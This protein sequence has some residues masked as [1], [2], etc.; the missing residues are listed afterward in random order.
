MGC[1]EFMDGILFSQHARTFGASLHER[2]NDITYLFFLI[3]NFFSFCK[4]RGRIHSK[5]IVAVVVITLQYVISSGH[6][7]LTLYPPLWQNVFTN[8]DKRGL[9]R[10]HRT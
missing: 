6:Q 5:I 9:V 8:G 10:P 4:Q 2:K 1:M 7:P 3:Y